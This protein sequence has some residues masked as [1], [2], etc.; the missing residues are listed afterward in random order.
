MFTSPASSSYILTRVFD[1]GTAIAIRIRNGI[2]V[3][4][5]S[6]L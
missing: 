2:I 6:S 5:I 1:A 3:H 4:A